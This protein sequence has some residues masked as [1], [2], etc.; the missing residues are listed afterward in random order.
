LGVGSSTA[1]S[2]SE[3]SAIKQAARPYVAIPKEYGMPYR[4]ELAV[5]G[6]EDGVHITRDGLLLYGLYAPA[7]LLSF[8]MHGA[9]QEKQAKYRRGPDFGI[10]LKTNPVGLSGWLHADILYAR[11]PS[12]SEPF[13]RW[14][15]S[16]T[17][18]SLFSEGAPYPLFGDSQ[19]IDWFLFTSQDN[20][21]Y[22]T[23]IWVLR[24]TGINPKG[25]GEPLPA[26][27]N[28]NYNED[29]PHLERT[30][31]NELVLF[32]D[33]DNRPGG[34]GD[35]DIWYSV[36][37]DVGKTWRPPAN[38]ASINTK[39][40]EH[41]PHLFRNKT[42]VW[43]LYYSAMSVDGKLGIFRAEQLA[44]G[45]WNSWGKKELVIGAG[46]TAG[47][48]EPTLTGQGD[49]SFVVVYMNPRGTDTNRFDSDPWFLSAM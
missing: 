33:S 22:H 18:R 37:S 38:V 2:S 31:K 36:S 12:R 5:L 26:P 23:D 1:A 10:D 43:Y 9:P 44:P 15:L 42:G 14:K 29:N 46:N 27:L 25:K 30:G 45:D 6:W 24:N 28:S 39:Q 17:A 3:W 49:I 20:P 35:H 41:Q 40:K 8:Y 21:T 7:D 13:R 32:F 19:T 48:G 4:Q 34:K 11:R 47:V 16:G